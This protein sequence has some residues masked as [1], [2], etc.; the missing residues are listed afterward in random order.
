MHNGIMTSRFFELLRNDNILLPVILTVAL[1]AIKK[2]TPNTNMRAYAH[3]KNY[4]TSG[5]RCV[6][7]LCVKFSDNAAR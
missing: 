5:K 1:I 7:R 6:V 3:N 4:F 2:L